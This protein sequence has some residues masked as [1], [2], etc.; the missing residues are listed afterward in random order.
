MSS[1]YKI[2]II[3]VIDMIFVAIVVKKIIIIKEIMIFI[4][5]FVYCVLN[6]RKK[7]IA[8]FYLSMLIWL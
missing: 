5:F 2:D 1:F 8:R 6:K 4:I 3:K 7:T